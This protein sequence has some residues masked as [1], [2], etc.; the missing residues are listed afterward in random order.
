MRTPDT[1]ERM[2]AATSCI[3]DPSG[4]G[5]G[6][7]S[8]CCPGCGAGAHPPGDVRVPVP[9]AGVGDKVRCQSASRHQQPSAARSGARRT[10]PAECPSP[11]RRR[12][13]WRR[14][15]RPPPRRYS[16]QGSSRYSGRGSAISPV[17]GGRRDPAP[18]GRQRRAGRAA[19]GRGR[20]AEPARHMAGHRRHAKS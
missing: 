1:P 13:L 11:S 4:G 7:C 3:T 20:T 8:R 17:T 19:S 18:D 15:R 6:Q 9:L 12:H 5:W 2:T 10:A 14:Q 16:A